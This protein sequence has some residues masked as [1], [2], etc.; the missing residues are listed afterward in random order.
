MCNLYRQRNIENLSRIFNARPLELPFEG[1]P[2]IYPKYEAIV[3]RKEARERLLECM[4]WGIIRTMPG[5]SGKPIK[6]AITNVRNLHSP[7]WRATTANPAQ[8]CLVP[9][10]S[11]AEPGPA[12]IRRPAA[13]RTG[14]LR[15]KARKAA[16]LPASGG[17]MKAPSASPSSPGNQIL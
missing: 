6:K 1:R 9:F 14:D 12:R 16:R 7:F 8:R 17:S 10:S 13:A 11:F 4:S 3:V 15:S 2:D 5:K